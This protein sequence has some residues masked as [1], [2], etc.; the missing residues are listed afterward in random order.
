PSFPTRRSS[1]L[2][3]GEPLTGR[4]LHLDNL[5]PPV[6][7]RQVRRLSA[8]DLPVYVDRTGLPEGCIQALAD[9][10]SL[11][12]GLVVKPGLRRCAHLCHAA[13]CE[14]GMRMDRH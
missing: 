3:Q 9:K 5:F 1:D 8:D 12:L 10:V 7:V 2:A 13:P 11:V 4:P 14:D 6:A